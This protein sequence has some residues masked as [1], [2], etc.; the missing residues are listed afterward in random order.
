MQYLKQEYSR[1]QRICA[2]CVED[3]PAPARG[4]QKRQLEDSSVP[5]PPTR[6]K[7]PE[8]ELPLD[9]TEADGSSPKAEVAAKEQK[10]K[11]EQK[12]A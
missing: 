10:E 6:A 9:S 5:P 3:I 4:W 11:Q 1:Y 7:R 12:E 2:A 8:P